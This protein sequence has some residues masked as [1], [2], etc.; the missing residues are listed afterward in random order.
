ME[1]SNLRR[2]RIKALKP[3][4]PPFQSGV[5][6]KPTRQELLL[7]LYRKVAGL[8]YPDDIITDCDEVYGDET[9]RNNEPWNLFDFS[10]N[11]GGEIFYVF[12][13]L[14]KVSGH[15][16]TSTRIQRIAGSGTWNGRTTA[17]VV[18]DFNGRIMGFDKYYSFEV[19][20][21]DEAS[22]RLRREYGRWTMHELSLPDKQQSPRDIVLCV[23]GRNTMISISDD[24]ESSI[25]DDK[26]FLKKSSSCP[27][28]KN[29][30]NAN[31][32]NYGSC[33]SLET[34]KKSEKKRMHGEEY[35]QN[36]RKRTC[37]SSNSFSSLDAQSGSVNGVRA[38]VQQ[39]G[40]G[41]LMVE[42]QQPMQPQPCFSGH[43]NAFYSSTGN[44][45]R[46]GSVME[47]VQEP[48]Q[49]PQPCFSRSEN[50]FYFTTDNGGGSGSVTVEVQQP[51]QSQPC[52][53]GFE[54]AFYSFIGNGIGSGSIVQQQMQPQACFSGNENAFYSTTGD[55]GGSGSVMMEAQQPLAM[56]YPTGQDYEIVEQQA[57]QPEPCFPGYENGCN[58]PTGNCFL[59]LNFLHMPRDDNSFEDLSHL[60]ELPAMP[61][62]EYHSSQSEPICYEGF[63]DPNFLQISQDTG[64][65]ESESSVHEH[66]NHSRNSNYLQD[67][68]LEQLSHII[69]GIDSS[70]AAVPVD[71][72]ALPISISA[73][74]KEVEQED[75][76]A[77]EGHSQSNEATNNV[78]KSET[79]ADRHWEEFLN[80]LMNDI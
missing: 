73:A 77:E 15:R 14:K 11:D 3:L 45:G 75:Q 1:N 35:E 51:M 9:N 67:P 64:L 58:S 42:V 65:I 57:M 44:D 52:F 13:C 17:S 4:G 53:P 26:Y 72:T 69:D 33:P 19:K 37:N 31:P 28:I 78:E 2:T 12:T 5:C 36:S 63:W 34:P 47:E 70:N 71:S 40:S 32:T 21:G 20:G 8:P 66:P 10:D 80:N 22:Q 7:C 41:S 6:F 38:V 16:D 56:A 55:G 49:P 25:V 59:D 48:M 54:N 60:L 39:P 46:S 68:N 79:E 76:V 62:S 27:L 74:A 61:Q 43:E 18:K 50:A 24:P 30:C 23:I 29:Q